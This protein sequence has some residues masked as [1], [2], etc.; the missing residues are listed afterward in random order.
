MSDLEE[1]G[2]IVQPHASSG[3]VPSDKGYR[4]YVDRLMNQKDLSV[5]ESFLLRN[6]VFE[7]IKHIDYLMQETAKVIAL[8]TKYTTIV[9]EPQT[10]RINVKHIQLIPLDENSVII[11]L[12][13]DNKVVK[14]YVLKIQNPPDFEIL[15]RMSIILT[16]SLYGRDLDNETI[17]YVRNIVLKMEPEAS[18]LLPILDMIIETI[19]KETKIQVYTSGVKNILT[20]PEFNDLEK[21]KSVFQALEEKDIL[22][23]LLGK[24]TKDNVQIYIGN[25]SNIEHMKDCSLIRASYKLG[26]HMYGSIGIIGPTRMN[27]SQVVSV[28]NGIEKNINL[29]LNSI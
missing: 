5:E 4:L 8:M 1:M 9:T 25:E 10:K 11:V 24:E 2:F 20:Y 7:N 26:N 17:D 18:M 27:Y 19:A 23:T 6:L 29:V 28:L 12:V 21:A 13:M 14:N 15:N 3:R 22:I 16:N